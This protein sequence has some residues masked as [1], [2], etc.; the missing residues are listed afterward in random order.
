[1]TIFTMA[2]TG[3]SLQACDKELV[4]ARAVIES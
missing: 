3:H 2:E 1:V 4:E